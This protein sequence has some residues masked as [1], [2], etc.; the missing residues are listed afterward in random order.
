MRRIQ[1]SFYLTIVVSAERVMR[2][3]SDSSQVQSPRVGQGH[4]RA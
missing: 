2:K 3:I 1:S 4:D